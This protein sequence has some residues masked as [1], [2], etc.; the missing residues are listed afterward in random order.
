MAYGVLSMKVSTMC[1]PYAICLTLKQ[2]VWPL[3]RRPWSKA[4]SALLLPHTIRHS[5]YAARRHASSVLVAFVATCLVLSVATLSEGAGPIALLPFENVS[6]HIRSP[7]LIMPRLAAIL[8]D[9]GYEVVPPA[10]LEPF[11]AE[12][13]IRATGKLSREQLFSLGRKFG[14]PWA[15][16]GSIDLFADTPGNPQWGLSGRLLNTET[17]QIVWGDAAGLTGEDFTGFLDLGTITAP[18]DLADQT[19]QKF[20]RGL[21]L[22]GG[23]EGSTNGGRSRGLLRRVFRD[24]NLDTAPPNR[25]AILPFENGT[26]R[27]GAALIMDDLMLVGLFRARH[28]EVVDSGETRRVLGSLGLAPYGA[29][30]LESLRSVGEA[31]GVDAVILG[32]VE[33]YNEGL[34]PA[35][36]TSPSIAVNARMLDVKSGKILWMGYHEARGEDSQVVLEF[37]KIKSM[38]PLAMKV[39]G[40]MVQTMSPM[41]SETGIPLAPNGGSDR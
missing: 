27:R 1:L 23:A 30:D 8:V 40:E 11:L 33:D 5:S 3:A 21:R 19:V 9:R 14:T 35:A 22:E 39:I 31:A 41:P 32:R 13:R 2:R 38:V 4:G 18:E 20:L 24:P 15:L 28:F 37:G 36:S 34:R 6:G 17:G 7:A 25:V 16:V 26:E 12:Q 10:S 29:I